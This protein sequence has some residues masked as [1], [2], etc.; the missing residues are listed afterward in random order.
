MSVG[1]RRILRSTDFELLDHDRVFQVL[2]WCKYGDATPGV[3]LL[4][5]PCLFHSVS[6]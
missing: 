5:Y 6:T 3:L 1:F 2:G 4:P